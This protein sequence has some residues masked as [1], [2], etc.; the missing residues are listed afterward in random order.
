MSASDIALA[1]FGPLG[2]V[3]GLGLLFLGRRTRSGGYAAPFIP[4]PDNVPTTD[5][6]R[7]AVCPPPP[8][9][10]EVVIRYEGFPEGRATAT[11]NFCQKWQI[12]KSQA[13]RI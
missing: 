2:I 3:V 7:S 10:V 6:P 12:C 8:R 13:P 4:T 9:R 11:L 1:F 5:G